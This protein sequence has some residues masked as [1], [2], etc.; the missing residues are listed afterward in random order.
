MLGKTKERINN[1]TEKTTYLQ[2]AFDF[3]AEAARVAAQLIEDGDERNT[4]ILA[5]E[6]G[7]CDRPIDSNC[8]FETGTIQSALDSLEKRTPPW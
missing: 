1:T 5:I 8:L 2:N 7:K 6:E 3:A 4:A